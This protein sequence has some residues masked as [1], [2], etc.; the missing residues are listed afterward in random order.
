MLHFTSLTIENRTGMTTSTKIQFSQGCPGIFTRQSCEFSSLMEAEALL[1]ITENKIKSK[2][3]YCMTKRRATTSVWNLTSETNKFCHLAYSDEFDL[4]EVIQKQQFLFLS[5]S[6][7]HY[8]HVCAC[9]YYSQVN[10]QLWW[11]L[12]TLISEKNICQMCLKFAYSLRKFTNRGLKKTLP[13][14]TVSFLF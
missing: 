7:A 2:P 1:K 10:F 6:L 11:K 3:A 5:L 14:Q 13:S 4:Q 12:Y 9:V 8:T